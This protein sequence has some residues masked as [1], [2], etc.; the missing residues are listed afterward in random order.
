MI[1]TIYNRINVIAN[2]PDS[3]REGRLCEGVSKG[4]LRRSDLILF[5][6]HWDCFVPAHKANTLSSQWRINKQ[7]KKE[8]PPPPF[9]TTTFLQAASQQRISAAQAMKLAEELYMNG[10]ISYP[11]TD[12]T[13]YPR[14]LNL[15]NILQKLKT[16]SFSKEVDEVLSNGRSYPTRGKKQTTDHPP[17]HPVGAP[18]SELL[19]AKKKIYDLPCVVLRRSIPTHWSYTYGCS[20]YLAE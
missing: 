4:L 11:R 3:Y 18:K 9:S 12:N 15:R 13:V 10:L 20:E 6:N 5:T 17:I 8:L 1:D 16:S 7:I 2:I 14:S 19:G